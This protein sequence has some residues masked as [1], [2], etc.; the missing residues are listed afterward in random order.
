MKEP[1]SARQRKLAEEMKRRLS[2]I[3]REEVD[4]DAAWQVTVTDV[5]VAR[6]LSRANVWVD[7][8]GDPPEGLVESLDAA[9]KPLR[10][11]LGR[12][13][14]IRRSP[15]LFFKHDDSL[16]RGSE[17]SSLIDQAVESDRRRRGDDEDEDER[18]S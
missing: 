12:T 3:I 15:E 18:G 4:H 7:F 17:L 9:R 13:M 10:A 5:E 1:T 14:Y 6:D 8:L 2:L 16:E 11:R